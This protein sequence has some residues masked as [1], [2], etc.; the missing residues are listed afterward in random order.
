M[1]VPWSRASLRPR[2]Q[3]RGTHGG[4]THPKAFLTGSALQ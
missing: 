3:S 4:P 1:D 2:G